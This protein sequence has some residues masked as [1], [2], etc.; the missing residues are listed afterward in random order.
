LGKGRGKGLSALLN[1]PLFPLPEG[2][3]VR[4]DNVPLSPWERAGER[5]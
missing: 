2:E 5:V 1:P 4:S 3:D